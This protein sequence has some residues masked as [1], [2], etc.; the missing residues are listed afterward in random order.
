MAELLG[1]LPFWKVQCCPRPSLSADFLMFSLRVLTST[2]FP[3]IVQVPRITSKA[4][5][6]N[7]SYWCR[8]LKAD[9]PGNNAQGKSP[10]MFTKVDTKHF[11]FEGRDDRHSLMPKRKGTHYSTLQNVKYWGT[12]KS[13]GRGGELG[14]DLKF[15]GT[16]QALSRKT[17]PLAALD[18]EG[19]QS[20]KT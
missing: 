2:S 5:V 17:W 1:S 20:S 16:H 8:H 19:I 14:Q 4:T 13:R 6:L 3:R 10:W 18:F 9:T 11:C 7:K 12:A 15:E